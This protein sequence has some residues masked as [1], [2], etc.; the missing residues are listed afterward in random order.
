MKV[1]YVKFFSITERISN[2]FFLNLLWIITCLPI[3]TILPS[4]AAMFGVFREWVIKKETSIFRLF[5]QKFKENFKQSMVL[6]LVWF[7]YGIIAYSNLRI[8]DNFNVLI[9]S[10]TLA[11]VITMGFLL[12]QISLYMFTLMV[13]YDLSNKALWKNA[14]LLSFKY[15]PTTLL[16]I[17]ILGAM[18]FLIYIFPVSLIIV[19]SVTAYLLFL[20]CFRTIRYHN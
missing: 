9:H 5:F 14:L 6:E 1:Q 10:V 4:T 11:I 15:F 12:L 7:I 19:F 16:G 13:H 2:L 3:I 17:V 18:S 20:I 8:L